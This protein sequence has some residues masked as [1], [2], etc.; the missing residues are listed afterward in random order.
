MD[1][2]FA[3]ANVLEYLLLIN[4]AWSFPNPGPFFC[5][6]E[7]FSTSL[8]FNFIFAVDPKLGSRVNPTLR[9]PDGV[10]EAPLLSL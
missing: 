3:V 2:S 9:Q 10:R 5:V 1:K 4:S 8:F 6:H 7:V